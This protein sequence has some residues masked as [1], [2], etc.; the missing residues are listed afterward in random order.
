MPPDQA[1]E[2]K[3]LQALQHKKH[4]NIVGFHGLVCDEHS[5]HAFLVLEL[6][7]KTLDVVIDAAATPRRGVGIGRHKTLTIAC[8]IAAGLVHCHELGIMHRDLKPQNVLLSADGRAKLCDFGMAS[9]VAFERPLTPQMITLWYRAPEVLL[10]SEQYGTAVDVW[11]LGCIVFEMCWLCAPFIAQEEMKML[12][13]VF[14]AFGVPSMVHDTPVRFEYAP[15]AS[16]VPERIAQCGALAG[17]LG[18]MLQ[19]EP[20]ARPAAQA[21]LAAITDLLPRPRAQ[22]AA[23]CVADSQPPDAQP[24]AGCVHRKRKY[25]DAD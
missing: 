18:Q 19:L 14:D 8:D 17:V 5:K 4:P 21:A 16:L 24:A 6:C 1:R 13:L 15:R 25:P 9:A 20:R 23:G 2:I 10:G 3:T 7:A 12:E 11:T 22:P